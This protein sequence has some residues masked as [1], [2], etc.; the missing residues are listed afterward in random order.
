MY[1]RTLGEFEMMKSV[2][3]A[4]HEQYWGM[5]DDWIAS[6]ARSRCDPEDVT[7]TL[8]E[9]LN[10]NAKWPQRHLEDYTT[11]DGCVVRAYRPLGTP[12]WGNLNTPL[13]KSLH[14][15]HFDAA[16]HLLKHGADINQVNALGRTPLHNALCNDEWTSVDFQRVNFLLDHGANVDSR[17]EARTVDA[18]N[19]LKEIQIAGL[20]PLHQTIRDGNVRLARNLIDAGARLDLNA[21]NGWT[22]LD[23]ALLESNESIMSLLIQRSAQL[24]QRTARDIPSKSP[25]RKLAAQ[26][27]M[28]HGNIPPRP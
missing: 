21:P 26:R 14:K 23:L 10:P 9:G 3:G 28:A 11:S 25:N 20:T 24:S 17:T 13:H 16:T 7:K 6:L 18:E 12:C 8:D 2:Y 15:G 19:N 22:M 27:L 1:D 4:Q 5:E